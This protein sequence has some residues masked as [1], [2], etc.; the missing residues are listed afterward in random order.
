[1][2]L[3]LRGGGLMGGLF[4]IGPGQ[5][6]ILQHLQP[7]RRDGAPAGSW[8]QIAERRYQCPLGDL[9]PCD[10]EWHRRGVHSPAS[11][12]VLGGYTAEMIH[13]LCSRY[14]GPRTVTAKQEER[15]QV[16]VGSILCL[17]VGHPPMAHT[18]PAHPILCEN[19]RPGDPWRTGGSED[20][21]T[22]VC[23]GEPPTGESTSARPRIPRSTHVTPCDA[24]YLGV[25]SREGDV[26]GTRPDI[27][28]SIVL[29]RQSG[30]GTCSDKG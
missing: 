4:Q 12:A 24:D 1:M 21:A 7:R 27:V 15:G 6:R 30:A 2:A 29:P 3:T 19:Q 11:E 28:P 25:R 18:R 16:V 20:L 9:C 13:W 26:A 10:D 8:P 23:C 5:R 14:N 17:A 22:S